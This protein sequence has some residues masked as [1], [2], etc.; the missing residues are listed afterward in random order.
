MKIEIYENIAIR[1]K[2]IDFV[3]KEKGMKVS[4]RSIVNVMLCTYFSDQDF[5]FKD[6]KDFLFYPDQKDFD[7]IIKELKKDREY[8]VTGRW[9]DDL[10]E[11]EKLNIEEERKEIIKELKKNSLG[12]IKV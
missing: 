1:L 9:M 7:S 10:P 12:V 6:A 2:Q 5:N 11:G 3:M 4:I 8:H